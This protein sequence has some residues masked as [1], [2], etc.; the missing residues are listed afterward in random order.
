MNG[1]TWSDSITVTPDERRECMEYVKEH[2]AS[3]F[4]R[5]GKQ[6]FFLEDT[7]DKENLLSVDDTYRMDFALTGTADM[8]IVDRVAHQ[9]H[10]EFAG[11]HFV[12]EVKKDIASNLERL[13]RETL[14]ELIA[15]DLKSDKRRAPIGLLTDLNET[16]YFLWFTANSRIA[17]LSLQCPG[18]GFQ[19]I[20]EVL[21]EDASPSSDGVYWVRSR[22]VNETSALKR[23]RLA[24]LITETIL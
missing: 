15:A 24:D 12:I 18:D 10:E 6:R 14:L 8:V 13:R 4:V 11:L 22:F 17:T 7:A 21:N 2:L 9:Y 19:F 23:R 5:D 1:F 20:T 3:A 16:W